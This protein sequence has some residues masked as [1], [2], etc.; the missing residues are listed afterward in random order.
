MSI[1][2]AAVFQPPAS[3]GKAQASPRP[4]NSANAVGQLAKQAVSAAQEAGIALPKNAQ[5]FAASQIARG[6]D[7]A[8]LFAVQI[9]EVTRE[10]SETAAVEGGMPDQV[11]DGVDRQTAEANDVIPS[12]SQEIPEVAPDA[13][14]DP[15]ADDSD[16]LRSAANDG[17]SSAAAVFEELSTSSARV[18][19]DVLR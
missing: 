13:A 15:P 14:L 3:L 18:A 17:F 12:L 6:A 1:E 11:A 4:G 16:A 10:V 9:D 8:S 5:G 19:L 7:A 2:T